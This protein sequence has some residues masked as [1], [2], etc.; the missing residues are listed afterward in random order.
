MIRNLKTLFDRPK[1]KY[2]QYL[3]CTILDDFGKYLPNNEECQ[4]AILSNYKNDDYAFL[5]SKILLNIDY[6][7]STDKHNKSKFQSEI[8]VPKKIIE[9]ICIE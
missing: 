3:I 9:I 7:K 5:I 8:K 1:L 6:E 4:A 2:C